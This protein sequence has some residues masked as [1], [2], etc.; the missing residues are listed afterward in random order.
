MKQIFKVVIL[1]ILAIFASNV[2]NIAEASVYQK[3]QE[4]STV[5]ILVVGDADLKVDEFIEIAGT[6]FNNDK[7]DV[8]SMQFGDSV[9][10]QYQD[11]WFQKGYLEEQKLTMDTLLEFTRFSGYDKVLFLSANCSA[12]DKKP[13]T[14]IMSNVV[15]HGIKTR[16]TIDIKAYLV[17]K[18][19]PLKMISAL[20]DGD[21]E[22][23]EKR[24]K[25]YAFKKC[26]TSIAKEMKP[27][28]YS[29]L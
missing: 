21:S 12:I 15:D 5:A 26:V 25:R 14:I 17:S 9:Q 19:K 23:S 8:L 28:I 1:G 7:E 10:A 11:Y 4:S 6:C 24:A 16:V 22:E 3:N 13:Y 27:V 2:L 20:K 29:T 18:E